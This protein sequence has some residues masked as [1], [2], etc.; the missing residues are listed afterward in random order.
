MLQTTKEDLIKDFNQKVSYL[1]LDEYREALISEMHFCYMLDHMKLEDYANI[2]N[3]RFG[4]LPDL[5]KDKAYPQNEHGYYNLLCQINFSEFPDKLDLLPEKGMLYLF[6]GNEASAKVISFFIENPS[7][8][9]KKEPPRNIENLNKEYRVKPYDGFKVN[10]RLNYYIVGKTLD[11]IGEQDYTLHDELAI[12]QSNF[13]S[14]LL[15]PIYETSKSAYLKI[16]GF[17]ELQYDGVFTSNKMPENYEEEFQKVLKRCEINA[18]MN[19]WKKQKLIRKKEQLHKFD[20]EK[21]Q[22]YGLGKDAICLLSLE[23]L[24]DLDWCWSDEGAI[25]FYVLKEELKKGIIQNTSANVCS[26]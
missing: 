23:S 16:K 9:E 15:G 26:S 21:E 22:H 5:P 13:E 17:G 6:I 24:V 20:S 10:F 14:H 1:D 7:D 18:E 4:G 11:E 19:D 2:G 8:L 12:P 3:S 25:N